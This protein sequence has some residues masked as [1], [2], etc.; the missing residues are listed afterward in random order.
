MSRYRRSSRGRAR[1]RAD[2]A[3]VD[4]HVVEV[5]ARR[6]S[7]SPPQVIS[8]SPAWSMSPYTRSVG[9][10]SFG[11][12]STPST[13]NRPSS[14]PPG[15]PPPRRLPVQIAQAE[16]HAR[17]VV[18]VDVRRDHRRAVLAGG[19][20]AG[21]PSGDRTVGRDLQSAVGL[22][23]QPDQRRV[24]PDGR[25]P[26]AHRRR[27]GQCGGR[28]HLRVRRGRRGRSTGSVMPLQQ[29]SNRQ[30]P[31]ATAAKRGT[32]GAHAGPEQWAPRP[33]PATGRPGR[34]RAGGRPRP[35]RGRAGA[36]R[37][38]GHGVSA[39][40]PA[41]G[42]PGHRP[43]RP[44]RG[45]RPAGRP[46]PGPRARPSRHRCRPRRAASRGSGAR[47]PSSPARAPAPLCGGSTTPGSGSRSTTGFT[48]GAG[49]SPSGP[50]A[51]FGPPSGPG[52]AWPVL[53]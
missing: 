50:G 21:E 35:A 39:E 28:Q 33:T 9:N 40:R 4:H 22:Q 49:R 42:H 29:A 46:A 24:D 27:R 15:R 16:E 52:A 37:S 26:D 47:G 2:E 53:K 48:G 41:G 36:A 1:R 12:C 5:A 7:N 6:R 3:R 34:G 32:P 8:R 44:H 43:R 23:T 25:D 17:S 14:R 11:Y 31:R 51:G 20:G 18:P 19:R 30:A 45:R 38:V 13:T 10:A